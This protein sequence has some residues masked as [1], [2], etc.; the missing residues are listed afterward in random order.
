VI[1]LPNIEV[2]F[3]QLAGSLI[4]RSARG[5]AILIVKDNTNKTFDLKEYKTI[6]GVE[7]DKTKYTTANLQYIKDIFNFSV[8]KVVVIRIDADGDVADALETIEK[9][10]S[11]GWITIAAGEPGEFATLVSWVKSMELLRKTYKAVVHKAAAPDSKH[12]VNFYND[13]VIFE[14]V[15]RG[16]KSGE[17][18]CPSLI[19]ILASCN[20]QRG[21][22][23]FRCSNLARVEE[24]ADND[25]AAADGKFILINDNDKVKVALGINS[26]T[27]T[28]GITAT[29]D[30][31]FIDTVEVMDLINDD[32]SSVFKNEYLG[33]Y[34]NNYDNQILFISAVNTYFKALAKDDILDNNYNN[35][36]DVD[37]EGQRQAW[38]SVGKKEA[39]TWS[40]LEVKLNALKRTVCL[41]GDVKILGTMENLKFTVSLF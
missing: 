20:V 29:E 21:S 15:A 31:K 38:I 18:Y 5:I 2:I 30:M 39:E 34:K 26:L 13:N 25:A 10:F 24:V 3:K 11:T 40:D 36:A 41:A 23:Y 32:I 16:E 8:N 17:H 7:Q 4:E 12:I 33:N 9:N 37:I 35:R 28:D 6:L 19:G 22:T 14:D 27:T 1:T